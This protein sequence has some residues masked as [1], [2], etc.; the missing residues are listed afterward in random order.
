ME[1]K[2]FFAQYDSGGVL[3]VLPGARVDIFAEGTTTPTDKKLYDKDGNEL[4]NPLTASVTGLV[5]FAME[6]GARVDAKVTGQGR[7]FTVR[8]GFLDQVQARA[9]IEVAYGETLAAADQAK[10]ASAASGVKNWFDSHSSFAA[11]LAT[12]ADGV[13]GIIHDELKSGRRTR[14]RVESHLESFIEYDDVGISDEA[15]APAVLWNPL[16]K[17]DGLGA[18]ALNAVAKVLADQQRYFAQDVYDYNAL[19]PQ[20]GIVQKLTRTPVQSVRAELQALLDFAAS[21]RNA[22]GDTVRKARVYA[23]GAPY[24]LDGTL[25]IPSW[26]EFVGEVGNYENNGASLLGMSGFNDGSGGDLVRVKS[27]VDPTSGVAFWGGSFFGFN[28][29]GAEDGSVAYGFNTVNQDGVDV[30]L[31]DTAYVDF[32]SGRYLSAGCMR[33]YGGVPNYVRRL[34]P[35]C[36]NGPGVTIVGNAAK[37]TI[38]HIEEISGDQCHGGLIRYENMTDDD[39]LIVTA[40]KSERADSIHAFGGGTTNAFYALAAAWKDAGHD[41]QKNAIVFKNCSGGRVVINGAHH[42]SAWNAKQAVTMSGDTFAMPTKS[43]LSDGTPIRFAVSAGGTLPA[44]LAANTDYYVKALTAKTFKVAAS[45]SDV[46]AGPYITPT[47]G[48]GTLYGDP[49]YLAPGDLVAIEGGQWPDVEWS[50]AYVRYRPWAA[51]GVERLGA[52]PNIASN[53]PAGDNTGTTP[54]NVSFPLTQSSG[55]IARSLIAMLCTAP[56]GVRPSR[57]MIGDA[58]YP[59]PASTLNEDGVIGAA[60]NMPAFLLYETDAPA[61]CKAA[62]IRLNA[63]TVNFTAIDEQSGAFYNWL[64][65]TRNSDGTANSALIDVLLSLA[66]GKN[67]VTGTTVGSSLGGAAAQK[68][69]MHGFASAQ[70]SGLPAAATDL[71]T[72]I[73]LLNFIRAAGISKGFW[74]T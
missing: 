33:L 1:L 34:R 71:T 16:P 17:L 70:A 53:I 47:G 50:G 12:L 14:R 45:L 15:V 58:A 22:V 11:A 40:L 32:L 39:V 3:Y 66:D 63:G 6:D 9:D 8:L 51:G 56:S 68:V 59:I 65:L 26:L 69:G 30:E 19:D 5:Q 38:T 41:G 73:A 62:L 18:F 27:A 44:G 64:R 52:A 10:A 49:G 13:Y 36:C 46:G 60:G 35:Y 20:W 42:I 25:Y 72:A 67:I 31:Q 61:H 48:S 4:S 29:R 74:A 55:R 54:R 7:S 23:P 57:F 37:H 2:T 24:Y 43:E 28:M 21:R